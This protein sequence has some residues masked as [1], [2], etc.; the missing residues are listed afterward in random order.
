ML[1]AQAYFAPAPPT[2]GDPVLGPVTLHPVFNP[3]MP[4]PASTSQHLRPLAGGTAPKP[5]TPPPVNT[6]PVTLTQ[7]VTPDQPRYNRGQAVTYHLVVSNPTALPVDVTSVTD[8]LPTTL[9]PVANLLTL[10][11]GACS[12]CSFNGTIFTTGGFT[13]P[14]AGSNAFT[15]QIVVLGNDIQCSTVANDAQAVVGTLKSSTSVPITICDVGLG[16]ENWWSYV[17]QDLGAGGRASMNAANGNLVVQVTDSTPVQAHG[18]WAYVLK[19]TYNSEDGANGLPSNSALNIAD[20]VP[21]GVGWRLNLIETNGGISDGITPDGLAIPPAESFF[22]AYAVTLVDEDGTR[23]VFTP[24]SLNGPGVSVPLPPGNM[25]LLPQV[26]G[27]TPGFNAVCIDETFDSP[28]GV[29]MSMWRYIEVAGSCTAPAATPVPLVLGFAGMRTDR[30]RY[31]FSSDG[32]LLAA[33]DGAGVALRYLYDLQP[34]PG[35]ALGHLRVVYE[36]NFCTASVAPVT[37]NVTLTPPTC[38]AFVF[39]YPSNTETDVTDPGGRTTK[40]LLDSN[41]H[42][43]QVVNAPAGT[44]YTYRYGT[45]S[46]CLSP[47]SSSGQLCAAG[48]LKSQNTTFSYGSINGN[49]GLQRLNTITDRRGFTTAIT[50][51]DASLTLHVDACGGAQNTWVTADRGLERERFTCIDSTGAVGEVAQG[52]TSDNYPHRMLNLWDTQDTN[53]PT[54][55]QPSGGADHD[56]CRSIRYGG[57]ATPAEDTSFTYNPEGQLLVQAQCLGASD[58][59]LSGVTVS[60]PT[61]A[62]QTTY[63]Y[64]AQYVMGDLTKPAPVNDSVAGGGGVSSGARPTGHGGVLYVISDKTQSLTPNG[65]A[66]GGSYASYRT[67]YLVDNNANVSPNASAAAQCPGGAGCAIDSSSTAVASTFCPQA[68]SNSGLLCEVDAP[69]SSTTKYEYDG[70][71]Q[72]VTM[73]TPKAVSSSAASYVYTYFPDSQQDLSGSVSAGGWLRAVTD[74]TGNFVA[75]GY[76]QAGNRVRTWSRNATAGNP[77]SAFPG[78]VSSPPSSRYAEMLYGSGSAAYAHPWRYLLSQRDPLG[79]VSNYGVDSNGNELTTTR[80]NGGVLTKQFDAGDNTTSA[81]NSAPGDAATTYAYDGFGNRTSMTNGAGVVTVYKYDFVNRQ[82]DVVFTRGAWPSDSTTV[83]PSCRKSTAADAPI[84]ANRILCSSSVSYDGVDNKTASSDG[85]GQV[86]SYV[87]DGVHRLTKTVSPRVVSSLHN[88]TQSIYDADGNPLLV[89]S[90]RQFSESSDACSVPAADPCTSSCPEFSALHSYDALDRMLGTATWRQPTPRATT[91]TE[92]KSTFAY[93]ADGNQTSSTDANTHTST[94]AYNLLDRKTSTTIPRSSSLNE[95]TNWIYDASGNT[96][97]QTDPASRITVYTYDADNRVLD[98][99]SGAS[100]TNPALDGTPDSAGGSNIRTRNLYDADGNRVAVYDPRAF[101]SSV[102]SPDASFVTNYV[103]DVDDRPVGQVVPRYDAGSHNDPLAQAQDAEC[104]TG[105]TGV[106]IPGKSARP[107]AV[108]LPS[109]V[110]A[111]V[112]GVDYDTAGNRAHLYTPAKLSS[113]DTN[114]YLIFS[115]TNDNLLATADSPDPSASGRVQTTYLYD[116]DGKP[117]LVTDPLGDENE[118]AYTP[119]ELVDSTDDALDKRTNY[120]YDANGNKISTTD[121]TGVQSRTRYYS[122]DTRRFV[123]QAGQ[124][125]TGDIYT[126]QTKNTTTYQYDAAGNAIQVFSPSGWASRTGAPYTDANN[127]SGTPTTNTYS[128]DNLLL[129]STQPVKPDGTVLRQTSYAYDAG[130]LKLSQ[131]IFEVTGS[132]SPISGQDAGTQA[133]TYYNDSRLKTQTSTSS[134]VLTTQYDPAGNKSQITDSGGPTLSGTYYLDGLARTV[135]DGTVTTNYAYDGAAQLTGRQDVN[136]AAHPTTT[137]TY[138]SAQLLKTAADSPFSQTFGYD[139]AGRLTSA[140][141]NAGIVSLGY[142]ANNTLAFDTL[143]S[144]TNVTLTNWNYVYDDARRITEQQFSGQGSGGTPNQSTLCYAY[145]QAGRLSTA[146]NAALGAHCGT[147]PAANI[148]WD[149]DNN[150]LTYGGPLTTASATFTYNAD[151]S[152]ATE[153]DGANPGRTYSE[154]A[155]GG[156]SSDGCATYSYDGFF[157]TT[158]LTA[159]G[160]GLQ[161]ASYTYDALDRTHSS[162]QGTTT[163]TLHYDGWRTTATTDVPS[164]GTTTTYEVSPSDQPLGVI[165]GATMQL[166]VSDGH[167]KRIDGNND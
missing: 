43:S 96:A 57:G 50:Y 87:F 22:D 75:F 77:V 34:V 119:D 61:A 79:N 151:N 40:Y 115:Y 126:G 107:V 16:Y 68:L 95:T 86:T 116:G 106:T 2:I 152:I 164:T 118:T 89:C 83:P 125:G 44:S 162:T 82:T 135:G 65:N 130:G 167:A 5:P 31:E 6:A 45:E 80:P 161:T 11:G 8:V 133:F 55:I 108:T 85:N 141:T 30:V 51:V 91:F 109:G 137:Y 72:K 94:S 157:R 121:P 13:L 56:L 69:L 102:T 18:R 155:F 112:T 9:L 166:L 129:T 28:A 156:I 132:G 24:N 27:T 32:H 142:N 17:N 98:T 73:T 147:A 90:P 78:S 39:S 38:R 12:I 114:R 124:D 33:V 139:Q 70:N 105:V 42:L 21:I 84:P 71:G 160:C 146:F 163:H 59:S 74:P 88:T 7:T 53:P 26:L 158:G 136:G 60:C 128:F 120:D 103:F 66:A 4:L 14:P 76:D 159:T 62:R 63:G 131:H 81:A 93:D 41:N 64:R 46:A 1:P 3:P 111:C 49:L 140:N 143:V 149:H 101:A 134:Q 145:D 154:N 117:V 47:T 54:C 58:P 165:Q 35:V 148:T 15:Y 67:T 153:Q 100:S 19:R 36:P 10:N 52:D 138:N 113:R 37:G 48:D 23:H 20:A 92:N 110:G 122:D 97:S 144:T 104:P 127:T 99:I 25:A 150:R 123:I 29:H